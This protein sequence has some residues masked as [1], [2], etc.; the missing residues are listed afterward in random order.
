MKLS[1]VTLSVNHWRYVQQAFRKEWMRT[2]G[3]RTA[4]AMLSAMIQERYE[5][6]IRNELRLIEVV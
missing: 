5:H 1:Q 3:G 2:V 4:L 6:A